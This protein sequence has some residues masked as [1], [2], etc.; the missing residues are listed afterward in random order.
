MKIM[1]C[2]LSLP[3]LMLFSCQASA[4]VVSFREGFP[5]PIIGGT[6]SGVEDVMLATNLIDGQRDQNFGLR[7]NIHVG[8]RLGIPTGANTPRRSLIR[9]DVTAL[10][11]EFVSIDSVILR[12]FVTNNGA[13]RSSTGED[14]ENSGVVQVRALAPANTGWVEGT[15]TGAPLNQ[16]PDI[17]M[18]T[19]QQR[20]LGSENWAGQQG[21]GQA[22]VDY[23]TPV[24][25]SRSFD[26]ADEATLEG[27]SFDFVLN[28]TSLVERWTTGDNAGLYLRNAVEFDNAISFFSSE[29]PELHLRPELIITFTPVPEPSGLAAITLI[30]VGL[31]SRRR[32]QTFLHL[33]S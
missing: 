23:L 19:W 20:V 29:A 8:E 17:G 12:L 4:D 11:N 16:P 3:A 25:A 10:E 32:H 2:L 14:I 9:F 5:T 27:S 15:E 21:A 18:S 24:L 13:L 28:N 31:M 6:Y 7:P 30:G 33:A 26:A 1:A 22:G